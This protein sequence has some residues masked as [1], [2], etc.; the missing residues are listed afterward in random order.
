[1]E[2]PI[3]ELELCM[4]RLMHSEGTIEN[5]AWYK[6]NFVTCL[7]CPQHPKMNRH[8]FEKHLKWHERSWNMGREKEC[9]Q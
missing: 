9:H 1:M 7:L 2:T 3:R 6:R 5:H 8:R 4:Y